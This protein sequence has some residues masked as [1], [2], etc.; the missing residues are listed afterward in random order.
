MNMPFCLWHASQTKLRASF[1]LEAKSQQII[2]GTV[3]GVPLGLLTSLLGQVAP[4]L[5]HLASTLWAPK[6]SMPAIAATIE[7]VFILLVGSEGCL[8]LCSGI[9]VVLGFC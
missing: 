5:K 2:A 4:S 8:C 6:E 7:F 3:L 1:E 9:Q